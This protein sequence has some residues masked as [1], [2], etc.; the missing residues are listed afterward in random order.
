[1]YA[2]GYLLCSQCDSMM[3]LHCS[4]TRSNNQH[5]PK[6]FRA[7]F[8][9]SLNKW[10]CKW[11][12]QSNSTE[13]SIVRQPLF[14]THKKQQNANEEI[15]NKSCELQLHQTMITMNTIYIKETQSFYKDKRKRKCAIQVAPKKWPLGKIRYLWNCS[16]FFLQINSA[17]RGGFRPHILQNFIAIFTCVPKL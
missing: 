17:Y 4:L 16:K 7:S 12:H 5:R 9:E 13:H 15:H 3:W 14:A 1:M 8:L 10:Q 11:K 2:V 6:C